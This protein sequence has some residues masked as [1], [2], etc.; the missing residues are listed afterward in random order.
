MIS[1]FL[2]T[3]AYGDNTGAYSLCCT[4]YSEEELVQIISS[5]E[6]SIYHKRPFMKLLV[7]VYMNVKGRKLQSDYYKENKLTQ[8]HVMEII[9]IICCIFAGNYGIT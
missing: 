4:I 8:L 7:W 6:I 1:D 3:C 2:A 9:L 5:D